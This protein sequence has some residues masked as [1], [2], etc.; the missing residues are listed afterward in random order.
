MQIDFYSEKKKKLNNQNSV[1]LIF[2]EIFMEANI[3]DTNDRYD[4]EKFL[5]LSHRKPNII[6]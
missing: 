6:E 1:L 5:K 3:S 2:G 4:S